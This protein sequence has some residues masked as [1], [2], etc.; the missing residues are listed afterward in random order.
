VP[1]RGPAEDRRGRRRHLGPSQRLV[2]VG[3]R[4]SP[5][6][7][8]DGTLLWAGPPSRTPRHPAAH[9]ARHEPVRV[10]RHR[11]GGHPDLAA[12]T[13]DRGVQGY[14]VYRTGSTTKAGSTTTTSITLTGLTP[15][16]EYSYYVVARDSVNA[17]PQSDPVIFTTDPVPVDNED[18]TVPGKPAVSAITRTGATVTW[19]ASSDNVGVTG[20]D[21]VSP[22]GTVLGSSHRHVTGPHRPH[23]H[24][25][26]GGRRGQGRGR[27]I[28]PTPRR[29]PPSAP[30][31]NPPGTCRVTYS[32]SDWDTGFTAAVG[33]TNTGTTPINGWTLRFSFTAG[34][35][36]TP[37]GWSAAW[38]QSGADVTATHL[39]WSRTINPGQTI[40]MGF[41]GS[42]T[43]A[44]P[45]PRPS[46][47][48]ARPAPDP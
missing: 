8:H 36:V 45:V 20:Y 29:P 44:T 10:R 16:T 19:I 40:T 34:Q 48:T 35:R 21:V 2:G 7:A 27:Q 6:T 4:T 39:D 26:L 11:H 30:S 17:G 24:R 46:P 23:R 42:H 15:G 33:I 1:P 25:V 43:A 22:N 12:A 14:D 47:S 38:T 28:A 3:R 9:Q 5:T 31:P 13:D 37:P 18:P 41:N 32:T